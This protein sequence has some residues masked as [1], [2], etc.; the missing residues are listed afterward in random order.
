MSACEWATTGE[1]SSDSLLL[2][3][4]P[5]LTLSS[6]AE[7]SLMISMGGG[8]GVWASSSCSSSPPLCIPEDVFERRFPSLLRT[9]WRRRRHNSQ[10]VRNENS[11]QTPFHLYPKVF[12]GRRLKWPNVAFHRILSEEELCGSHTSQTKPAP[13]PYLFIFWNFCSCSVLDTPPLWPL[14][15]RN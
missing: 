8:R 9:L 11:L 15:Y 7:G 1:T 2:S 3:L 12:N 10:L 6:W 13:H 5:P 14:N 4:L